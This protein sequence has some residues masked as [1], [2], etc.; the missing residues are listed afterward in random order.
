VN[1]VLP[2]NAQSNSKSDCFV[3]RLPDRRDFLRLRSGKRYTTG[4]FTLQAISSKDNASTARLN[5]NGCRV[6]YTVTT[7]VGN[8][9]VRNRIKRRLRAAVSEIFPKHGK[10]AYDYA[11]IARRKALNEEFAVIKQDLKRALDHVHVN[12]AKGGG[13]QA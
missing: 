1:P 10:R 12:R 7:R 8:A 9:V 6:G 4:N 5:P 3:D 13:K 2:D 11:L